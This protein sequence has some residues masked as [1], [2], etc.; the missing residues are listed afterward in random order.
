E[1]M[2]S[3]QDQYG[4]YDRLAKSDPANATWQRGLA[5]SREHIGKVLEAKGE[6]QEA[7]TLYRDTLGVF[8]R[9]AQADPGNAERQRDLA[10]TFED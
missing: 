10:A 8:E 3:Y 2:A 1:A 4:V 9:Q 5:V 7:L 6:L